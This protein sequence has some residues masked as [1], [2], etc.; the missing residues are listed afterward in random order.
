MSNLAVKGC[1]IQIMSGQ[2]ASSI[3]VITPPSS[4]NSVENDGIY[5]G[6]IK[7]LL[8]GLS[9]GSMQCPTGTI[10]ISG[11]ASDVLNSNDEKAVQEGDS[12]T[13]TFTF[14]DSSSGATSDIPVTVKIVDAGQSDVSV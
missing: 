12:G 2:T 5:F 6:D 3:E 7:V 1:D 4:D 11:T 9:Q 8:S 14:T 13:D 10:T